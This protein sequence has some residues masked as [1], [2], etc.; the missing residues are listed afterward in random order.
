[1]IQ[2]SEGLT[3]AEG[4][5]Q[6]RFVRASGPGGQNVRKEA[7]A[8][9]LQPRAPLADR[10]SRRRACPPGG[11]SG[12]RR[13]G[14]K[15]TETDQTRLRHARGAPHRKAIAECGEAV[16]KPRAARAGLAIV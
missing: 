16:T 14:A 10:E 7:T 2:L 4:E 13:E 15:A 3:V 6:E 5:I 8:V 12:A 1:M 11:A 9:E